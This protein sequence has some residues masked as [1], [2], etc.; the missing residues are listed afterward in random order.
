MSMSDEEAWNIIHWW[1]N[2][3]I[4]YDPTTGKEHSLLVTSN[5]SITDTD[6]DP[7]DHNRIY[8]LSWT[9]QSP[10]GIS[11]GGMDVQGSKLEDALKTFGVDTQIVIEK[12]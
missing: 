7:I 6:N 12:K 4:E 5:K 10:T 3:T 1:S 8:F 9:T 2:G 11:Q